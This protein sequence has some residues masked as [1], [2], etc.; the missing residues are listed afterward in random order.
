MSLVFI[1]QSYFLVPKDVRLNSTHYL[2]MKTHNKRELQNIAINHSA[3]IY[4]KDFMKNY[5]ERTNNIL[6]RLLILHYQLIILCISE[7]IFWIH[8][9]ITLTDETKILNNKIT[10]NQ[11]Q[12]NLDREA[13]KI[14]ALSSKELD[15]YEHLTAGALGC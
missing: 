11:A 14:S 4:Y 7:K 1:T 9:K 10:T 2:I 13:A 8:H 6:F 5:K 12:Y 15:N 3:D